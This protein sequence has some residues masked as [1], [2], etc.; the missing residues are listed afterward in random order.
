MK[1]Y[2]FLAFLP[3]FLL[4]LVVPLATSDEEP[5]II[6]PWIGGP[7]YYATADQ[8]VIIRV[9]WAACNRGLTQAFV[10]GN[11]VSM[12]VQYEG[13]PYLVVA[14]P[15]SEYWGPVEPIDGGPTI[16]CVMA[17]RGLWR[18][19]WNYSL[20]ELPVGEYDVHWLFVSDHPLPDGGDYDGDGHP[21][22]LDAYMERWFKI[23]VED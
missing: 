21:D 20:G 18:S 10:K 5:L 17:S 2:V 12:E 4:C 14:P 9:G 1:R 16:D 8:E 15:A 13:L 22:L 6:R 23:I 11:S 3:I 19:Y 7:D